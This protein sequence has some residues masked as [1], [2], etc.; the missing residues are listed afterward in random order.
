MQEGRRFPAAGLVG[1]RPSASLGGVDAF[2]R[3]FVEMARKRKLDDAARAVRVRVQLIESVIELGL[4]DIGGQ[5]AAN[6]RDADLG[7]TGVLSAHIGVRSP[8]VAHEDRAEPGVRPAAVSAATRS[9]RSTKISSR[10]ILPSSLI[11]P[12]RRIVPPFGSTHVRGN[13][14]RGNEQCA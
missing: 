3:R 4:A 14:L 2:G 6:R 12:T 11:A 1:C 5:I 13:D 7:A 9:V 10:V 8:V